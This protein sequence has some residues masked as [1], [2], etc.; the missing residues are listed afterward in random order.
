MDSRHNQKVR[1]F[2]PIQTHTCHLYNEPHPLPHSTSRAQIFSF[3]FD[4]L[5]TKTH[6]II[7][8]SCGI[9]SVPADISVHLASQTL[10][11][12]PLGTS[13][14]SAA[15][16]GGFPGGTIASFLAAFESV[17]Q[18]LLRFSACDWSLSP[19]PGA[20]SPKPALVYRLGPGSRVV[21]GVALFNR[22]NRA[23]VQRTAG[24]REYA[25]R[26]AR[27]CGRGP[28]ARGWAGNAAC[29]GPAFTYTEFMPTGNA[30]SAC[31]SSLV[32]GLVFATL[33]FIAPVRVVFLQP[34][35]TDPH[36]VCCCCCFY[37][38]GGR[39]SIYIHSQ[40]LGRQTSTY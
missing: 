15:L 18:H 16:Y 14:T 32:I 21:G 1:Y 37:R 28:G 23:L 22:V 11:H 24:L 31:V 26:E 30:V 7:V 6:A 20:R 33:A 17:P 4:Y 34:S 38:S 35:R 12:A 40:A 5:A 13:T 8:P 25:R 3:R 9:D 2:L 36:C 27:L 19:V 39:S 29:Y 10:A